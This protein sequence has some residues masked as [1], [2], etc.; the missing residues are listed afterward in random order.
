MT[1]ITDKSRAPARPGLIRE[2]LAAAL[3]VAILFGLLWLGLTITPA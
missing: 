2:T 3:G 1:H